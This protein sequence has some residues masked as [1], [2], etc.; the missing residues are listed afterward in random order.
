VNLQDVKVPNEVAPAQQDAIKAREDRDRLSLAAQAYSNDLIPRARGSA[1]RA[2]QEAQ[3]YRAQKID[4]AEG[5]SAR[6][7][8]LLAEYERAPG[9]TRERLYLE[10]VEN[11]L[12]SSKKVVLD[13]KDGAGNLIYLPIDKLLEQSRRAP[14]V[15]TSEPTVT[16]EGPETSDATSVTGDRRTR[17]T[18]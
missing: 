14:R 6:F 3:A 10:T 9:V 13:T 12:A 17:G 15:T 8:A 1:V 7:L 18:R 2:V 5:E 11:V 4:K 16:V